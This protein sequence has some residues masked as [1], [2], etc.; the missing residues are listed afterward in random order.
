V[1]MRLT[2]SCCDATFA[3]SW[4]C[5]VMECSTLLLAA[6]NDCD[7]FSPNEA[8]E[9]SRANMSRK[10]LLPL[11]ACGGGG[12]GA[13]DKRWPFS[14]KMLQE[15]GVRGERGGGKRL[16]GYLHSVA[17]AWR[18]LHENAKRAEG[19]LGGAAGR[20]RKPEAKEWVAERGRRCS[21][22]VWGRA[23]AVIF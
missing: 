10:L 11:K 15:T 21:A 23:A 2:A 14:V 16:G 17:F 3:G 1:L 19:N 20:M 12:G 7:R 9:R 4:N 6:L 18:G 8:E 22:C 13:S 5:W